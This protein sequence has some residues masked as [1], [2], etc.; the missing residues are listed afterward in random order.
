M[1]KYTLNTTNTCIQIKED[2]RNISSSSFPLKHAQ[3]FQQFKTYL[4]DHAKPLWS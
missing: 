3:F 2:L 1:A 4:R